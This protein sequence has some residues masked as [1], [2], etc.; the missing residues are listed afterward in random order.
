MQPTSEGKAAIRTGV[1]K[2]TRKWAE[3]CVEMNQE[4]NEK[5]P[6]TKTFCTDFLIRKGQSREGV[7]EWL[8]NSA[9]PWRRRRR[10]IQVLAGTFP[11]GQTLKK[12][13]LKQSGKCELCRKIRQQSAGGE[14]AED[15]L[16]EETLGH[17]NSAGCLGQSD[18]V[19][20]AHNSCIKAL[21]L[22]IARWGKEGR[23]MEFIT[24]DKERTLRTLWESKNCEQIC[25]QQE[26][27]E[28]AR[29]AEKHIPFQ[30][31]KDDEEVAE[32]AYKERFWRRRL[33]S[34]VLD[35][36]NK[37]AYLIE[38]KRTMDTPKE[39]RERTEERAREQYQSLLHGL[40]GATRQKR[41][42]DGWKAQQVIFVGGVGGSL[43]EETFNKNLE[44]LGVVKSQWGAIR[45]KHVRKLLDETDKVLRA[46]YA[47]RHGDGNDHGRRKQWGAEQHLGQDIYG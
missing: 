3:R 18:A 33:D 43:H 7:G 28:A 35:T 23:G 16:P 1:F 19:T 4:R 41:V 17:I 10:L 27:W 36:K 47:G 5:E 22:D 37:V 25:T 29:E 39:Y 26:L 2:D 9:I 21:M 12:W 8:S 13:K 20:A 44:A 38:F 31:R 11:C 15:S 24:L 34:L 45:K 30:G 40:H 32:S 6:A 42:G 46:Y 14:V